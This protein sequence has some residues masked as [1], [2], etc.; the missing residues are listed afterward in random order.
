M[1]RAA[2]TY[3]VGFLWT[4]RVSL[5]VIVRAALRMPSLESYQQK[6]PTR[7]G[8]AILRA[9]NVRVAWRDAHRLR[10]RA[11]ILVANHQSWFDIFVL[12]GTLP[13]KYSFVGKKEL[14]SIPG[15]GAAWRRVGHYAID[16]GDNKA[17]AAALD[18]VGERIAADTATVVMFPEGTRSESE[19]MAEFK[20]GAFL[21]AIKAQVPVVPVALAGTHAVM[22]KGSWAIRPGVVRVHVGEPIPTAGLSRRDRHSLA[23]RARAAVAEL[24]RAGDAAKRREAMEAQDGVPPSGAAQQA[25]ARAGD[26]RPETELSPAGG[27]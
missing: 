16:R 22:P 4:F 10:P 26:P 12:A 15:F 25:A 19:R 1:I 11:Q 7:W 18:E 3:S 20:T 23:R 6:G 17:A 5:M 27:H 2:W 13:V 14:A 8:A 9:A 24:L 21:L